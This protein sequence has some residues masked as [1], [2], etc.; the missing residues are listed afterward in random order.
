[1]SFCLSF[2]KCEVAFFIS[3]FFFFFYLCVLIL[4]S[5][6]H[7]KRRI[8]ERC[9]DMGRRVRWSDGQENH[10]QK[11][12]IFSPL[13]LNVNKACDRIMIRQLLVFGKYLYDMKAQVEKEKKMKKKKR[14]QK[15]KE[16]THTQPRSNTHIRTQYTHK[17]AVS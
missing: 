1:M 3:F 9:V 8:R 5:S 4:S 11:R 2:Q 15:K 17:H 6:I 7:P 13:F 14:K 12:A 10:Q 16:N